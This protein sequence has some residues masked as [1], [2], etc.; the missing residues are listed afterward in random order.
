MR[1]V[2]TGDPLREGVGR[3]CHTLCQNR[4]SRMGTIGREDS[5]PLQVAPATPVPCCG[6][7]AAYLGQ[8]RPWN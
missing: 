4:R 6:L 7:V 5:L 8:Y 3:Y 1:Y 2:S